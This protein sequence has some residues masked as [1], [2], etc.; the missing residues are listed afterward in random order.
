MKLKSLTLAMLFLLSAGSALAQSFDQTKFEWTK[1]KT[2]KPQ[3]VEIDQQHIQSQNGLTYVAL[4]SPQE[5]NGK[6]GYAITVFAFD[7]AKKSAATAQ[8][9][10]MPADSGAAEWGQMNSEKILKKYSEPLPTKFPEIVPAFG[11]A[12]KRPAK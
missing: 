9:G 12:C 1:L 3:S 6:T 2:D 11:V 7:C 4:R 8:I 5:A 10:F